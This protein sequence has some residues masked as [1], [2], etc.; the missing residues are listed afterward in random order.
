MFFVRN[1]LPKDVDFI[2]SLAKD[3]NLISLPKSKIEIIKIVE[4]STNAFSDKSGSINSEYVFVLVDADTEK[5][6]GV[7]MIFGQFASVIRPFHFFKLVET[8]NEYDACLK[9]SSLSHDWSGIGGLVVDK[10]YRGHPERLGQ[11]IAWTRFLYMAMY[12]P[13]FHD[14]I[15]SILMSPYKDPENNL[16]WNAVGKPFTGMNVNDFKKLY[17]KAANNAYDLL[18]SYFPEDN[19]CL[20]TQGF[21]D[22]PDTTWLEA[23]FGKKA[24]KIIESQSFHFIS[25][26]DFDG[27][28]MYKGQLEQIPLVKNCR[29]VTLHPLRFCGYHNSSTRKY[30]LGHFP[31]NSFIGGVFDLVLNDDAAFLS[32]K[33][34]EMLLIN[35]GDAGIVCPLEKSFI[36]TQ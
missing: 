26:V 25:S 13:R 4:M 12:K 5:V 11:I 1:A 10:S 21:N 7:S 6:I 9:I 31:H 30:F 27:G 8:K 36:Q 24:R 35:D 14:N 3:S 33:T 23:N 20:K 19:I 28:I 17:A 29:K 2:C 22:K 18:K 34:M 15:L 32:E 16:F